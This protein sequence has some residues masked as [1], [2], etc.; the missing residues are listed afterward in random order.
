MLT[1]VQGVPYLVWKEGQLEQGTWVEGKKIYV[2]GWNG[3]EWRVEGPLNIDLNNE[4]SV[5]TL[6]T[7]GQALYLSWVEGIDSNKSAYVLR[8]DPGSWVTVAVQE[9]PAGSGCAPLNASL[10]IWQG[11]PTLAWDPACSDTPYTSTVVQ[12]WKGSWLNLG[13][14]GSHYADTP[15]PRKYQIASNG[16]QLSLAVISQNAAFDGITLDL[17]HHEGSGWIQDGGPAN[18]PLS[19]LPSVFSLAFVQKLPTLAFRQDGLGIRVRQW[20]GKEWTTLG[21]ALSK[22]GIEPA[23]AAVGDTPYVGFGG[24]KA[25]VLKWDGTTWSPKGE[26]LNQNPGATTSSVSLAAAGQQLFAA[27]IEN[28]SIFVK[29]ISAQ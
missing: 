2:A 29:S 8:K 6:T 21:G 16:E 1:T 20:T 27:W 9:P 14:A 3:T 23:L 10:A 4:A 13:G 5:P 11:L 18:D 24:A 7:D 22:E 17:Y 15:D 12:Q 19:Y 28:G 26:P 25:S